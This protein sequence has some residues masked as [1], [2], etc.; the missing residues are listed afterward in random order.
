MRDRSIFRGVLWGL[1]GLLFIFMVGGGWYF[2]SE[3][4]SDGFVPNPAPYIVPTGDY[5]IQE[6]TYEGD[7]GT[8]DALYLPGPS[9]TWVI[10]VHGKGAT[11]AEPEP[12]FGAIQEAGY[13]Q[14][15][16]TYRNDDGQPTDPSGYYQYGATEWHDVEAAVQYALDNGASQ[17]VLSGFSTGAAHIM[18]YLVSKATDPVVGLLFDA[19]NIDMGWTVDYARSQR[20]LPLIGLPV[21]APL[22]TVAKFFTSLRIDVNWKSIDYL[23]KAD[24]IIRQPALVH[25]GDADLT[26]PVEVSRELAEKAPDYVSYVEVPGAGHV[27]SFD[28]DYANYVE[29][30]VTFLDQLSST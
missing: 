2:S 12:I 10:H 3:V 14:L 8:Y 23:D 27:D 28:V 20:D 18:S 9:S 22:G 30:V 11:P 25:H 7:L 16:I 6:V 24:L 4:I 1:V 5:E 29:D 15:S 17:V 19:P 26:V 13:P 21:P